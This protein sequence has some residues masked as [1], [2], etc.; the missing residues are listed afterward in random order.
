MADR[1]QVLESDDKELLKAQRQAYLMLVDAL[2]RKLAIQPRTS[3][4]RKEHKK[5]S[6]IQ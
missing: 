3:E 2:E 1:T 5:Q 4:L 6:K